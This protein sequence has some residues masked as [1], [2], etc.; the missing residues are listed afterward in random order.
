MRGGD[1]WQMIVLVYALLLSAVAV[2]V[3]LNIYF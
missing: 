1:P 2:V 3:L